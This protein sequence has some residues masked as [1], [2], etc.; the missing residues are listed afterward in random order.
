MTKNSKNC[1]KSDEPPGL[2]KTKQVELFMKW[3]K[4]VPLPFHYDTCPIPSNEVLACMKGSTN[5]KKHNN[6]KAVQAKMK[7]PKKTQPN[8]M[9]SKD[10]TSGK[11]CEGLI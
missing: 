2:S 11:A 10:S 4:S 3:R 1:K 7:L 8:V 9:S 6:K 5:V